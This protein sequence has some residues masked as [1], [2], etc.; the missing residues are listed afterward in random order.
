MKSLVLKQL[1]LAAAVFA[2]CALSA[3]AQIRITEVAP[4]SSGTSLGADWFELTNFGASSVNLTGWKMD[5][6][7]NSFSLSVPMIDVT[8]IAAGESVIFI[9]KS[10]TQTASGNAA[11]FNTLWFGAT[12]PAGLQI[13]DYSGG[14]V[15]LGQSGDAVN[16]YNAAGVLQAN[17]VFGS[18]TGNKTFDNAA[19]LNNTTISLVSAVGT[20]G[21]FAAANDATQIGSPGAISAIPE[22]STYALAL[23]LGVLGFVAFCRKGLLAAA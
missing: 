21:A 16:V 3:R 13:G 19:G 23:G 2:T 22:P 6:N 18:A 5:D 20:N 15:G 7:S 17:V 12:P 9:E 14:G 8:S 4:A 11:A 1:V 10:G